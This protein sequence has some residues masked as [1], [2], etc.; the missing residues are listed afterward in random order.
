MSDARSFWSKI[1]CANCGVNAL[2]YFDGYETELPEFMGFS[3]W[4]CCGS[5]EEGM[6]EVSN[7]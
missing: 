1:C 2:D 4:Y 7:G 3:Q 5:C 6:K